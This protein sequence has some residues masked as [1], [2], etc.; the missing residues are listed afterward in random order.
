MAKEKFYSLW[1]KATAS[2][3]SDHYVTVV[4]RFTQE[5]TNDT[6]ATETTIVDDNA[7]EHK[8]LVLVDYKKKNRKFEMARAICDPRDTFDYEYGKRKAMKRIAEGEVIGTINSEDITMLN[9]DICNM[10]VFNEVNHVIKNIDSYI[11]I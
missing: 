9:D 6:V 2:D 8:A 11:N 5:K 10:L 1:G 4:G 3:G 7:K